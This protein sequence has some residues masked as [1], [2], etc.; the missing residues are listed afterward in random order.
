[1]R[2]LL[3][4]VVAL[5][6]AS[7]ASAFLSPGTT[8]LG[9]CRRHHL[10]ASLFD[11]AQGSASAFAMAEVQLA[12]LHASR[13]PDPS[14]HARDERFWRD[15]HARAPPGLARGDPQLWRVTHFCLM[16]RLL[17]WPLAG[18]SRT[19][20]VTRV[21]LGPLKDLDGGRRQVRALCFF[22]GLEASPWH[23]PQTI[24]WLQGGAVEKLAAVG[25]VELDAALSRDGLAAWGGNDC[26]D[27]DSHG[28]SQVPLNSYGRDHA[29]GAALFPQ[30]LGLLN[31]LKAPLG[32]REVSVVKQRRGSGLPRHSDQRNYMLTAHITLRGSGCTLWCDGEERAWAQGGDATVIDTTFWHGTRNNED[33]AIGGSGVGVDGG[34]VIA[35]PCE[36]VYVLLV[37]F[38]HPGLTSEERAAL[39]AFVETEGDF[40][41]EAAGTESPSLRAS[42]KSRSRGEGM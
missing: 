7:I 25:R 40:L 41:R 17:S 3:A 27:F 14:L 32:P 6:G 35:P 11:P 22:P 30:T 18:R 37:D 28:W 16:Q 36:D 42:L 29:E 10:A 39:R 21:A 38:W 13:C 26:Q 15:F 9:A 8:A 20:G 12:A 19:E 31:K 24:G 34:P 5:A 1:M 23:D 33:A 4:R 2:Q